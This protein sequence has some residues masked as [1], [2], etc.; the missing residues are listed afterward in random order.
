MPLYRFRTGHSLG[1]LDLALDG[2]KFRRIHVHLVQQAHYSGLY[3]MARG[4]E[5]LYCYIGYVG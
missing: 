5:P 3:A 4:K 1:P 2:R